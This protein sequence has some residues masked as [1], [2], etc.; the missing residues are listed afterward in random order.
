MTA[1]GSGTSERYVHGDDYWT[2]KLTS[3]RTAV[4]DLDCL[5]SHLKPGM[6][7]RDCGC[8]P[9]SITADLLS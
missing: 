6:S 1:P 7:V 8:G 2:R 3:Q 9:V 4:R 5:S